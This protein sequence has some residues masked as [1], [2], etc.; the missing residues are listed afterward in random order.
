M[1]NPPKY[2]KQT[3]VCCGKKLKWINCCRPGP[4]GCPD[5]MSVGGWWQECPKCGNQPFGTEL[6]KK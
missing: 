5:C 2:Y 4:D 3:Q 6:L 1:K